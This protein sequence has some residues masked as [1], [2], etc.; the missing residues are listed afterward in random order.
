MD[1]EQESKGIPPLSPLIK[2]G[3]E[4]GGINFLKGGASSGGDFSSRLFVPHPRPFSNVEKGAR[5]DTDK[6]VFLLPSPHV[7]SNGTNLRLRRN[8]Y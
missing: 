8:V 5:K 6:T 4:G 3:A 1:K 2:G 7:E